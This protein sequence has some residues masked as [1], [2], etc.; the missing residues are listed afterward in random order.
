MTKLR[1][2]GLEI[3]HIVDGDNGGIVLM[4]LDHRAQD[5]P[6]DAAKSIDGDFC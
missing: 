2:R 5:K 4:P 3:R 1:M 6:T